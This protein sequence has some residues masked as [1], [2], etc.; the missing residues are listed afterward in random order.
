MCFLTI[1]AKLDPSLNGPLSPGFRL[2]ASVVF[3]NTYFR[4]QL[5]FHHYRAAA[6]NIIASGRCAP[7]VRSSDLSSPNHRHAYAC[8]SPC[9]PDRASADRLICGLSDEEPLVRGDCAWALSNYAS[10][11]ARSALMNRQPLE[12]DTEVAREISAALDAR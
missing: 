1:L 6:A 4:V 3:T 5:C 8:R 2:S 12:T 9:R 7:V 10:D 11:E